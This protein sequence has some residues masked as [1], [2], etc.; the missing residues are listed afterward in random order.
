MEVM[1]DLVEKILRIYSESTVAQPQSGLHDLQPASEILCLGSMIPGAVQVSRKDICCM[2][3]LG[4]TS[5]SLLT[6]DSKRQ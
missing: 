4:M 2:I 1:R 6:T 5:A 3:S